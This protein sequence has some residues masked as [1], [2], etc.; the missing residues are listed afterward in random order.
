MC[1]KSLLKAHLPFFFTLLHYITIFYITIV[2]IF[3]PLT[4]LIYPHTHRTQISIIYLIFFHFFY[5]TGC[6]KRVIWFIFR[7]KKNTV[8]VVTP[9]K[10]RHFFA[11]LL[12]LLLVCLLQ[13][14]CWRLIELLIL[15]YI[16]EETSNFSTQY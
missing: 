14:I 8:H 15:F 16:V 9:K 4:F 6:S 13:E 1:S 10:C 3:L 5:S 12:L 7:E 2:I 11:I